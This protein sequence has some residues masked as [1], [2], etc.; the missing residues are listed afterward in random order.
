MLS[1][2]EYH[3]QYYKKNRQVLLEKAKQYRLDNLERKRQADKDYHDKI[4]FNGVKAQVLER[5]NHTCVSCGMNEQA[6]I[7]KWGY[8]I[9]VDH[10]DGNRNNN[11]LEN[12]QTLCLSCHGTKDNIRAY[13][14]GLRV[15]MNQYLIKWKV[16]E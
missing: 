16:K 7:K 8:R 11:I 12:L 15:P 5:D 1:K 6:H 3:K 9:S 10:I 2:S 13:N 4:S 14:S